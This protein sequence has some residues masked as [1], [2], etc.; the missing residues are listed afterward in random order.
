MSLL[1][2]KAKPNP[3]GKDRVGRTFTPLLQLVAEWIDIKNTGAVP[4]KLDGVEL[5]HYAYLASGKTEW[6]LVT[7]FSGVLGAGETMRVHSGNPIAITQMNFEDRNGA[8]Y[9]IF[10]GKNYVWNN[11][12]AEFPRLWYKPSQQWLDQTAYDAFPLEGKILVRIGQKLI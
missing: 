2:T 5:Y 8:E 12:K 7:N 9:H 3:A 11:Y 4:L 6:Q 1:I 10:S